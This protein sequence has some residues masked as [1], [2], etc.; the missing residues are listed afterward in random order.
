MREQ[1][2]QLISEGRT[3]EALT[4]LA[5]HNGDAVLL[6]ARYNQA[7]KQQNMGMLD[8]SEWSKVQAQVNYAALEMA[9][10]VKGREASDT[11]APAPT[12]ASVPP[13]P[14]K[15]GV[16]ISYNHNDNFPMR[17]VKAHLEDHGIKVFVDIQDMGVGD[18]I[19][20]FIDK[21]FKENQF[22]LSIISQNSLK[23]GWVNKE[24]SAT[25][26]LSRFGSK[27]LPV[28]LDNSCFDTKFYNETM[29]IFDEKMKAIDAEIQTALSKGRGLQ[30]FTDER[31]RLKDL[32]NDFDST[33][34]NLKGHLAVDIN[35]NAFE[36]GM[37][38]VVRT[39]KGA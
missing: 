38:K 2:Q 27:W 16:F 28:L 15:P 11:P 14:A 13:Q 22:I 10:Q 25:F 32:Q 18:N 9:G 4:L 7:K 3:E 31:A 37:A 20:D 5:K 35:G 29:D 12:P 24:L 1:I 17:A 19:A 26:L 36:T 6:Q 8:F 34:Q 30:A 39:I 33:I 23:S 21:A